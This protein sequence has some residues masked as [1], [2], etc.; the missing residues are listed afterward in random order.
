MDILELNGRHQLLVCIDWSEISISY[1]VLDAG[2]EVGLE[3]NA[4]KST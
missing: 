1:T 4:V 3:V 2:K